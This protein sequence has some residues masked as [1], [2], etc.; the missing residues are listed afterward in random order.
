MTLLALNLTEL[1]DKSN[2][3]LLSEDMDVQKKKKV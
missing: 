3:I 2:K 1:M